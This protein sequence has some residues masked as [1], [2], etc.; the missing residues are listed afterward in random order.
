MKNI[1]VD[2]CNGTIKMN[3]DDAKNIVNE[4]GWGAW[5]EF[6]SEHFLNIK[7]KDVDRV[8]MIIRN[9]FTRLVAQVAMYL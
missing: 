7:L 3:Y 5:L 1:E 6:V 9:L 8:G 2:K 4:N